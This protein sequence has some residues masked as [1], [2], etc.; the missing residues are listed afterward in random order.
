MKKYIIFDL[1]DTLLGYDSKASD[2]TVDT[3]RRLE[4]LGHITVIN[5]A[6]SRLFNLEHFERIRPSYTILN[7]GAEILDKD[8]KSIYRRYID[9]ETVRAM[10]SELKGISRSIWVQS[11]DYVYANTNAHNRPDL[12]LCDFQSNTWEMDA[13]KV[14][15]DLSDEDAKMLAEK[16]DLNVFSYF[17]GPIKRFNHKEATKALANKKLLEIT[18]GSASDTIVFGDDFGDVDMIRESAHG[19]IMKNAKE[20]LKALCDNVTEY[21]N[22]ED[23]VARYLIKYFGL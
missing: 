10:L 21:E 15:V 1:D 22:G 13:P 12:K 9:K 16:Y 14:M 4:K 19:V 8:G 3:L 20:E 17:G 7:G 2:L 5:T 11:D 18:G 6:R 23:G